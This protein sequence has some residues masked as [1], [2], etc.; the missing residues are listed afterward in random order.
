VLDSPVLFDPLTRLQCCPPTCGAAAAILV[1]ETFA[2]RKGIP[3]E[4]A[5]RAQ[6][7]VTDT[8][9][10]LEGDM[11]AAVGSGMTRAA[12]EA[13]YLEAGLGPE[14]LQLLELHDCFTSNEVLSYEALGLVE[15]GGSERMICDGDNTYG[16]RYV[17]NPSGGLLSKGHPLGATGVAQCFELVNQL[18]G[19]CESR[20]VADARLALQHNIGLG[21]ACVVAM[22]EKLRDS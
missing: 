14:D 21:G 15:A 7:M 19:R 12:A 11:I 13:V 5:I 16:G 10:S 4:V 17:V 2:R 6:A 18:R 8:P 3:R 1:S 22:Y 9:T 20:Q